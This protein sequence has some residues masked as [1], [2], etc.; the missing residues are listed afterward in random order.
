MTPE[1]IRL[2]TRGSALARWQTDHV[3]ALLREKSPECRVEPTIINTKGDQILDK[4]LPSI[5]GKGLFTEEL[6]AALHAGSIDAA[7]HSLKDLPTE[8]VDG[9]V[10]RPVGERAPV[11]DV[12]ISRTGAKL[13]DLPQGAVI[14]TSSR[15]RAA[16]L[17]H[18]RPDLKFIDIRGNVQTRIKK[19]RD[20]NGPYDATLLAQAG[21]E[22]LGMAHEINQ[23]LPL[24]VLL[25][26][27]GQGAIAAQS[28]AGSK[29]AGLLAVLVKYETLLPV[30][31]ERAFLATLQG[32]CSVP[33][34]AHGT[35]HGNQLTLRARVTAVDGSK[36]IE[37][38]RQ[39][40]INLLNGHHEYRARQ[41]GE[42]AAQEALEKGAGEILRAV[43]S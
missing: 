3:A 33:V 28:Q 14:G 25:G 35:L 36:Q 41:L 40:V 1:V 13:D 2:G 16:Q 9:L 11:N 38:E 23:V 12:L 29:T 7:I 20:A 15:R 31:A 26:A 39:T 19:V 37:I 6:E 17:L 22:R 4:P 18:R 43:L 21:I 34:A 32:G 5:G 8:D 30:I 42:Q 24:D 27:P 10:H